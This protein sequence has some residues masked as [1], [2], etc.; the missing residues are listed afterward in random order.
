V[1]GGRRRCQK[2][3]ASG[4]KNF[5]YC[6][7]NGT[8]YPN[9]RANNCAPVLFGPRHHASRD[10][11]LLL[12]ADAALSAATEVELERALDRWLTA[13]AARRSAGDSAKAVVHRGLGAAE[14]SWALVE[15]LLP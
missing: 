5:N 7:N 14:R 15:G 12:D 3:A 2:A 6:T 10:A 9:L 13:P 4:Y 8:R 11:R 1:G